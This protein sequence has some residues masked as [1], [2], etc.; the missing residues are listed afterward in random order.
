MI[1]APTPPSIV[2]A[3]YP[4]AAYRLPASAP[5]FDAPS[6][7]TTPP[8]APH[9]RSARRP[10][11]AAL[12]PAANSPILCVPSAPR[13]KSRA[14]C[15][16]PRTEH[17]PPA[18]ASANTILPATPSNFAPPP[19]CPPLVA[20]VRS[21]IVVLL[22]RACQQR[23]D[24]VVQAPRRPPL[25]MGRPSLR[26]G[27]GR[28]APAREG[29]VGVGGEGRG[30]AALYPCGRRATAG[31]ER[32]REHERLEVE[33]MAGG[34]AEGIRSDDPALLMRG[35]AE[36]RGLGGARGDG[37]SREAFSPLLWALRP[38]LALANFVSYRPWIAYPRA[39]GAHGWRTI[40]MGARR[41]LNF[42]G[43]V[44]TYLL[45]SRRCPDG[46]SKDVVGT[47]ATHPLELGIGMDGDPGLEVR[48]VEPYSSLGKYHTELTD[49]MINRVKYID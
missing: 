49:L 38:P 34:R 18:S 45:E 44:R 11:T 25:R 2:P 35:S 9:T 40:H 28:T 17:H 4:R 13:H 5:T 46:L 29:R 33:S 8:R 14:T 39:H 24:D 30:G 22:V 7:D 41:V 32:W 21:T 27:R 1:H 3:T 42:T 31:W 43:R 16:T 47:P 6:A 48:S 23:E 10:T 37:G 19:P 36:V 26:V 15:S 12:P 20:V